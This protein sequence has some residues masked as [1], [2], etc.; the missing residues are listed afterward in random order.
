MA[1]QHLIAYGTLASGEA[2]AH[3][4][5]GLLHV[6]SLRIPGALYD[7]GAYPGLVT[8]PGEVEA[9][10]Y[11]L[12]DPALL[13]RL[14]AYEG[15]RP[16]DPGGSLFVRRALPVTIEGRTRDAWVYYYNGPVDG[17]PRI[18]SGSWRRHRGPGRV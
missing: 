10:L 16:G 15:Y 18:T 6:Q 3:L 4:C 13:P 14:D 1:A 17:R 11:A 8:G 2:P 9:E 5:D 7:L 12:R